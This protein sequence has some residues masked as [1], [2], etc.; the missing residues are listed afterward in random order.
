MKLRYAT[1][2]I[3]PDGLTQIV[4]GG[5]NVF[6]YEFIPNHSKASPKF[7]PF[8][9]N[10]ND[11]QGDNLYP[12]VH[13]LPD[14]TL[15]IFA[16]RDSIILDYNTNQ[17]VKTFPT[18]PGEPRNYP[19]AGSSV[20]LPLK[21]ENDFNNVEIL[22]CGG[23]QYGAFL[24]SSLYLP[25]SQSCGRI[26]IFSNEP[27]WEMETMPLRRTMG[28]MLLLPTQDVLIIN[29]AQN[30]C[31]GW[32]NAKNAALNPVMYHP[33]MPTNQRFVKMAPTTIARVYHST[34]NLLP[35]GRILVAGS[36]THQ[37]YT[38]TGEFPTELR[39]EAFLPPYLSPTHNNKRPTILEAPNAIGYNQKFDL[40]VAIN[41]QPQNMQL[42]LMSAPFS[43]HSF[44]QGQRLLSLKM[45]TPVV[46]GHNSYVI[47]ATSPPKPTIAPP[48]Y[49]MLFVVND[50]I[51]S[52]TAK[53]IN[54]YN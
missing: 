9:K 41:M 54:L 20:M 28:E 26:A 50:G 22:V 14:G 35:D 6:T 31:Q 13:L 12:F 10:T 47:S 33:M 43:T 46:D 52:D 39:L 38:L 36:N 53:W 17:V 15:F 18:I 51:P 44:S 2:Q 48:S 4:V 11:L 21:A 19:S 37:F 32:G 34:S 3:L 16:N 42:N 25:A 29:G 8:L 24:N 1:N 27:S 5:R 45:E 7:L 49:Y 40:K 23:A 30:G